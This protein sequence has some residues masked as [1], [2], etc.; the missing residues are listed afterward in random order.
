[1]FWKKTTGEHGVSVDPS[2]VTV[3]AGHGRSAHGLTVT[4][5]RFLEGTHQ[6]LVAREHGVDAAVR[7]RAECHRYVD[8]AEHARSRTAR[9]E[10]WKAIPEDPTLESLAARP[11]ATGLCAP[12][13]NEWVLE[14]NPLERVTIGPSGATWTA[15]QRCITRHPS[16]QA[17][18]LVAGDWLYAVSPGIHIVSKT[19]EAALTAC[20][21]EPALG[22]NPWGFH[23]A[24]QTHR[25]F[26][27]HDTVIATYRLPPT[28]IDRPLRQLI[29]DNG[30][31]ALHPRNG[32]VGR[33]ATDRFRERTV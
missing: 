16:L 9:L 28:S 17:C 22:I 11:N 10:A 32:I 33:F 21:S 25:L 19:G 30:L 13:A 12:Q 29:G 1:M 7:A 24:V 8:P 5:W 15:E 20:S 18:V 4:H 2:G 3:W 26:R 14:F 31:V 27:A 23:H 6:E